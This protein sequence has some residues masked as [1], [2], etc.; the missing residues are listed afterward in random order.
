[1]PKKQRDYSPQAGLEREFLDLCPDARL[2]E[3]PVIDPSHSMSKA[4][5]AACAKGLGAQFLSQ[6]VESR[7]RERST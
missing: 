1:M 3:S 5:R 6:L 7:R 2:K 4:F